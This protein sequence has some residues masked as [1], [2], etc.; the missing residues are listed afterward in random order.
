MNSGHTETPPS[1]AAVTYILETLIILLH[2]KDRLHSMLRF[3]VA[4]TF[5]MNAKQVVSDAVRYT[6]TVHPPRRNAAG[7]YYS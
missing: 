5:N 2:F 4:N 1:L 6:L 3:A 7:W